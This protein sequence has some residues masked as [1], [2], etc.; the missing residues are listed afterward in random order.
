MFL[1]GLLKPYSMFFKIYFVL[2]RKTCNTH[3][4]SQQK[5]HFLSLFHCTRIVMLSITK[6]LDV[7]GLK[8]LSRDKYNGY[9]N[10]D[11]LKGILP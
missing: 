9:C 2:I 4:F 8:L 3:L 11:K 7:F 5:Y 1:T 10:F 6:N